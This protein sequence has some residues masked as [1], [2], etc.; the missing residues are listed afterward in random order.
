MVANFTIP[1]PVHPIVMGIFL[2]ILVLALIYYGIK[3]VA[4]LVTGG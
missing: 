3:F 2:G 1:M 4:S